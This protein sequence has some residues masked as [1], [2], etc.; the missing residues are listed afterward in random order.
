VRQLVSVLTPF[1]AAVRSSSAAGC[2]VVELAGGSSI[3]TQ[4]QRLAGGAQFLF[5]TPGRCLD[6]LAHNGFDPRTV[7]V[8]VLDEADRLLADGFQQQV[9]ELIALLARGQRLMVAA[10]YTRKMRARASWLLNDPVSMNDTSPAD[11]VRQRAIAV[12]RR[13]RPA[14]LVSL[15]RDLQSGPALVFA[16]DRKGVEQLATAMNTQS[17]NALALHGRLSTAQRAAGIRQLATGQVQVLVATDLAARGIDIPLLPLVINYDLPRSVEL[18][19]HRI[20][21]TG[22]AGQPGMAISLIDIDSEAH[23]RL[24]AKRLGVRIELERLVGFEPR[25]QVRRAPVLNDGTG[26]IKG[27]RMSKKDKLRAAAAASTD[28]DQAEPGPGT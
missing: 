2:R 15:L 17:V 24:I 5:A 14:L 7:D 16:A 22:R 6:V 4:L 27:R 26:G 19:T 1:L 25:D 8:L 12:D 10:T 11:G 3:N 21:R 28:P 18:Y 9:D 23:W 20:G 13:S